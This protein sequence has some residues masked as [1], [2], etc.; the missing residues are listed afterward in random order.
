VLVH[1]GGVGISCD[2]YFDSILDTLGE[3]YW[4]LAL[5]SVGGY[6]DTD[7]HAP[8]PE[9]LQSRVD[10]LADFLDALCL[11]EVYLAGN[12]QGAW[13]AAKYTRDHPE[14][15]RK[16][17]LM[18]SG[19][20]ASA[21]NVEGSGGGREPLDGSAEAMRKR[22][23][24]IIHNKANITDDMVQ[25]SLEIAAR[26]GMAEA[27]VAFAEGMK[28]LRSPRYALKFEMTDWL[29]RLATPT[30]LIWGENDASALP[31]WGR[32]LEKMLPNIPFA[33]IPGAG[34]RIWVDQPDAVVSA[35]L[36]FF[37]EQ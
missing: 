32:A 34:H 13:V 2:F 20:I 12:S 17:F 31:E 15:V 24:G 21:M 19:T 36:A 14:R 30:T 8:V 33:W 27:Q 23:S 35:I 37:D 22:L 7:P 9:G 5:D 26:P 1:G 29:P 3:Q 10:H 28:R 16:L 18:A 25:R 11:D 6:G 4:T